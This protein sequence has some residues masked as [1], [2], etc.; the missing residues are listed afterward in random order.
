[1]E[2]SQSKYSNSDKNSI[3]TLINKCSTKHCNKIYDMF[4]RELRE[5]PIGQMYIRNRNVFFIIE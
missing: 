5:A 1:M 4:G 2:I 3:K